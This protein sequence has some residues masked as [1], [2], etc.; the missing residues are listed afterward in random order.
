MGPKVRVNSLAGIDSRPMVT[1]LATMP[2]APIPA[3]AILKFSADR[4]MS[5]RMK[6]TLLICD[7]D[8]CG[9]WFT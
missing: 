4:M 1:H 3:L 9:C 6:N 2:G 8:E 7:V 5:S